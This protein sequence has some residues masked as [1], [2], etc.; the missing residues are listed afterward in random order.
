MSRKKKPRIIS[1]CKQ[2]NIIF[3]HRQDI[4]RNFCSR[5]C[6]KKYL[7][8]SENNIF[9]GK[10]HSNE[11]KLK[12]QLIAK[13]RDYTKHRTLEY[14]QKQALISKNAKCGGRQYYNIWV[15]KYGQEIANNKEIERIK[16]I[17]LATI[18]KNNP[19]YGQPAPKGAGNGWCGWYKNWFFRSILELSF[20]INIIEKNNYQ[21]MS[22]EQ[23]KFKI[24]YKHWDGTIRNYFADFIIN[25][26]TMVEVKPKRLITGSV[27]VKIKAKAARRFCKKIGMRY[28]LT[29]CDRINEKNIIKLYNKGIIR[30]TNKYNLKFKE[31]YINV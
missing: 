20:M 12:F 17:S 5:I 27:L 4:N 15:Q 16:K 26:N 19:M 30:F 1:N 6:Y 23:Q 21:W 14:R 13:N 9:Y 10:K 11:T 29:D 24:P 2:C 28:L 7:T 31:K 3:E 8:I 22:A 25:N 18:G